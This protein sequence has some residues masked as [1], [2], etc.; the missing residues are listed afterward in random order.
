MLLWSIL[1]TFTGIKYRLHESS[2]GVRNVTKENST[3]YLFNYPCQSTVD[4]TPYEVYFSPGYYS[5][6]MWGA[7]GGNARIQNKPDMREDSGGHGAYVAGKLLLSGTY[8]FYLYLGGKGEDQVSVEK[9]IMSL[10]GYNGGGNGGVNLNESNPESGAGGGG[11]TDI[12]FV[13]GSDNY[14]Y[15]SRIMVAAGGGGGISSSDNTHADYKQQNPGHGGKLEGSSFSTFVFPGKQTEGM[16]GRGQ[17]G[18][19]F[20]N[21]GEFVNGGSTGGGGGGYYGATSTKCSVKTNL[22]ESAGGGGS[23][24]ISGYDGCK[25]VEYDES[26]NVNHK[27]DSIHYSELKF[28]SPIMMDYQNTSSFVDPY[29]K[30]ENGHIGNGFVRINI[31]AAKPSINIFLS[32]KYEPIY[33]LSRISLFS[34]VLIEVSS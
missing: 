25:A 1:F 33:L 26:G 18:L 10:G 27:E 3:S 34:T 17:D 12:R 21:G 20:S 19:N 16:F 31:I 5:I 30:M 6:E 28:D 22:C 7:S 2:K 24:Y 13:A 4:C 15:M 23:S 11:A 9:D 32:C 29:N 8:K 14:S